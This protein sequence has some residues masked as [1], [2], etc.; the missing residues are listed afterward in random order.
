MHPVRVYQTLSVLV[1]FGFSI[2]ATMYVPYLLNLGLTLA[3]VTLV[4]AVFLGSIFVLEIP[5]GMLADGRSRA[6]SV[7]TGILIRALGVFDYACAVGFWSSLFAEAIIGFGAA[8]ISGAFQAWL[9]DALKKRGEDCDLRRVFASTGALMALTALAASI[10]GSRINIIHPRLVWAVGGVFTLA[11]WF[12][13]LRWMNGDEGEAPL[14]ERVGEWVALRLTLAGLRRNRGLRW[15][16][17]AA[18]AFGLVL[19]FNYYWAPFYGERVGTHNLVWVWVPIYV[20][21]ALSGYLV[22]RGSLRI[23]HDTTGIVVALAVAG[24]GLAAIGTGPGFLIPLG[25][26]VLHEF[27]RGLYAPHSSTFFQHRFESANRATAGSV[28]SFIETCGWT[29]ILL[30]VTATT[31]HA[32]S[33]GSTITTVWAINGMLLVLASFLLWHLRPRT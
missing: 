2:Q 3:E 29:L 11:A 18:T 31:W 4:N 26:T 30:V 13:S 23:A 10:V 33:T 22:K 25:W 8:F 1:S 19:P 20:A 12:L 17:A 9:V 14:D 27:G 16:A 28:Q 7:K 5:T 21:T 6:W 32:P 15:G 24:V